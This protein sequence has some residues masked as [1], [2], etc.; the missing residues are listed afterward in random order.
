[1]TTR[2]GPMYSG[3]GIGERGEGGGVGEEEEGGGD[4]MSSWSYDR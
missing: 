1:M 3:A 2:T 4:E